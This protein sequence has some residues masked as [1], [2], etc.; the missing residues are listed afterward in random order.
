MI[1]KLVKNKEKISLLL[2]ISVFAALTIFGIIKERG[3]NISEEQI[4]EVKKK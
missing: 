2:V 4:L 1:K 3:K